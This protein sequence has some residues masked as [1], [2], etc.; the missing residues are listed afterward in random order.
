MLRRTSSAGGGRSVRRLVSLSAALAR[1]A[2]RAARMLAAA[3][4]EPLSAFLPMFSMAVASSL[5][6]LARS[7]AS[8]AKFGLAAV[9]EVPQC[10]TA[11]QQQQQHNDND[12][13]TVSSMWLDDGSMAQRLASNL[14]QQAAS[15]SGSSSRPVKQMSASI[16]KGCAAATITISSSSSSTDLLGSRGSCA[17]LAVALLGSES[18]S[19][20][21]RRR[22][23]RRPSCLPESMAAAAAA[24]QPRPQAHEPLAL[25]TSSHARRR[26]RSSGN[27]RV[28]NVAGDGWMVSDGFSE[29]EVS[30]CVPPKAI[31]G[32]GG[33]PV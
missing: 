6:L 8:A 33:H 24:G 7:A 22:W 10:P 28:C 16:S 32:G 26:R 31:G 17:S 2:D 15:R 12:G 27:R 20:H 23:R 11:E 25:R 3:S 29:C 19:R 9:R 5:R 21:W 30:A 14:E 4:L 18:T 1:R 13:S